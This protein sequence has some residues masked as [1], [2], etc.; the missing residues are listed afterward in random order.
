MN[1][2][3]T[4]LPLLLTLIFGPLM[5][6]S[7]FLRLKKEA[8]GPSLII[9]VTGVFL[10]FGWKIYE[11]R[12]SGN[13]K[14]LEKETHD[15]G[16][17]ELVAFTEIP[18]LLSLFFGGGNIKVIPGLTGL[19]LMVTGL[20]FRIAATSTLGPGYSLRIRK[21]KSKPVRRWPYSMVRHPAYMASILIHAGIILIFANI[22]SFF[23]LG[24]WVAV[25]TLRAFIEDEYLISF[26][27]Y[28][29]YAENTRWRIFP[30]I[31]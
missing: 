23:M 25:V 5:W 28:G 13:E 18:L 7:A 21:F 19:L 8:M 3:R 29:D 14:K 22:F 11:I 24:V 1:Y 20:Y 9:G 27:E 10:Y 17:V 26:P 15:K 31:F 12:F 2:L 4:I 16:S 30:W 6:Y